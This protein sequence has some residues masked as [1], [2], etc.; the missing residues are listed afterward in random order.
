MAPLPQARR[1][2]APRPGAPAEGKTQRPEKRYTP[3]ELMAMMRS[4][5]L[6][7]QAPAAAQGRPGG[8]PPRPGLT[9]RPGG[10][11]GTPA[12]PRPGA[13]APPQPGV[14]R[15]AA[16]AALPPAP[17][18]PVAEEEDD[19]RGKGAGAG[20]LG[21]PADRAGRRACRNERANERRVTSP[22]PAAALL[23]DSEEEGRRTRSGRK[24]HKM[25]RR[26]AVIAPR[27]SHAQIEPPITVRDLSEV[28]GIRAKDLI[29]RMMTGMGQLVN[30]NANLEE[31]TAVMLALEFGVELEI[32]HE[33]TA[34]DDLLASLAPQEASEENLVARPPVIT[35]L[36]HV[37]HG[38]TS[39]LD[40][41][42]KTNVVATESGGITQHIGA[43]QV[44]HD[45]KF[46]TFV[47]T[48]GHEAFTAMRARGANVT[49]IVVLVVA[50]D[51]GVMPQ[52]QE[53]I[54]HAKAADVPIV[55]ALNKID[56][57]N[58]NLNK[59]FGELSQQELVPEEYGG[60]TPV[61]KTSALTGQG[62]DDLLEMLGILAEL[63]CELKA[64]PTR[65]AT[66]TCLE[67]SLSEGRGVVA[68]MLVQDGTLRV[69]D[70]VVCGDG[71]GRV[72]A[73]FDDKGRSVT[74]AGPSMPVAV[75]GLDAVPTAG[76]TFAVTDD[77]STARE[78]AEARR[79]RSRGVSLGERQSITLENLYSKMAEQKVKSLNLILKADVQG[80]LEALLKE[81]EKLVNAEVPI[82][83][84]LKAVGGIT[85]SD[86]LLADASQAIVI[87]FRVVPED[88]AVTLA[89]EKKI[90]IRRYDIIY[91]VT[92]EIKK[93]IEG[94]LVPEIKEVHLGRAVV[95]Q[96][97]KISK[98]GTVA[99]CFVTQGTFERSAKARLIREGREI[100]KGGIDA[101]KRFKDDVKEVREGFE[102]GIKIANYD[103]VK[104]DD[105]IEAY[106][107]DVIRRTL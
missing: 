24:P 46:I 72:R 100:Y 31:E 17:A 15:P 102:C 85:E 74:V 50:A 40:R 71:F 62:I 75:S 99:G 42:R 65:P 48:P 78:V 18:P 32:V 11:A 44:E 86:I 106:R 57:P 101:L 97:F 82:R 79:W 51:D 45:G 10:P 28:I 88:R 9:P 1:P 67:A 80:S 70:V 43:Y 73:L 59:I 96:T 30:I 14:R 104:I 61:I 91:Q 25:G 38:K 4:G 33:R 77:I 21:T 19:R 58:V 94:M 60:D 81:L 13:G 69:G 84:L 87:G 2:A 105:V 29:Q 26:G 103:D 3:E 90:D 47:D 41:I 68:T 37:D 89:E 34:E 64:D 6:G 16:G 92:D 39:L 55:V 23:G 95:R 53:A 76:E 7:A 35:I 27:K 20:R 54:A 52:T 36:G 93:A 49:D 22:M 12:P 83:I 56:L 63:R 5:K 107:I 66:G 98:V 8:G